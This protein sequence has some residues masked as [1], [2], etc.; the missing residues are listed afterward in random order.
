M[1]KGFRTVDYEIVYKYRTV[2]SVKIK[3]IDDE[4]KYSEE[5]LKGV[6]SH[7]VELVKNHITTQK[8]RRCEYVELLH[9]Y[10]DIMNID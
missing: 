1:K 9:K 5:Q 7:F 3:T 8:N 4:I 10:C 6:G 2:L